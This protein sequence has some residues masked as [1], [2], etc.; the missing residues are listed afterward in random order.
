[1][2]IPPAFAEQARTF[3]TM[4]LKDLQT[5]EAAQRTPGRM[6]TLEEQEEIYSQK[7]DK[8]IN[9][10]FIFSMIHSTIALTMAPLFLLSTLLG[11]RSAAMHQAQDA[12]KAGLN[13]LGKRLAH[14]T[15][16][17]LQWFRQV[18]R[19]ATE[20]TYIEHF[21]KTRYFGDSRE[22][23]R[24]AAQKLVRAVLRRD[25]TPKQ[26][27]A[28]YKWSKILLTCAVF[29]KAMNG[30]SYG[31]S[32]QQP[33]MIFEHMFELLTFPFAIAQT[34]FIQNLLFMVSGFFSLG[35]AND[36]DNDKKRAVGDPNLRVYNMEH[37]K[38]V[39][40][41]SS[42]LDLKERARGLAQETVGMS[43]F[44]AEDIGVAAKRLKRDF[45]N[46]AKGNANEITSGEGSAGKASLNFA[47]LQLGTIPKLMLSFMQNE[48][49]PVYQLIKAYSGF[50]QTAAGLVGDFSIFL[51]GKDGKTL[52]ERLPVVG[53]SAELA[54]R[55]SSYGKG[56]KP[57]ATFLQ[58]IGEAGNT[59]F[60]AVR[61]AKL[62]DN[63]N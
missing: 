63:Q 3:N 19:N 33:S 56:E 47:L 7:R 39:F 42:G 57:L 45:G 11:G 30:I 55:V 48:H 37:L 60:Y 29:P 25:L 9:K 35:L 26:I 20:A 41:P 40:K 51:L 52:G 13:G 54:G 12:A 46:M 32:S 31:L 18:L 34:P 21:P 6:P 23:S 50:M 38:Q 10:G 1:M 36:L 28:M 44:V 14:N 16:H 58:K 17:P 22:R 2:T 43:K 5:R 8:G 61:S 15:R 24:R 27:Q 62:Q 53:V 49:N 4:L 59:L